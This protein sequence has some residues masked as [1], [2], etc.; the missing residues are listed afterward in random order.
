MHNNL[1]DYFI[2]SILFLSAL[3]GYRHGLI[4]SLGKMISALLAIV[5]A[6]FWR[7]DFINFLDLK[8]NIVNKLSKLIIQQVPVLALF[9]EEHFLSFIIKNEEILNPIQ[10][11]ACFIFQPISF[12]VLFL[13][14]YLFLM[15]FFKVL[16]YIASVGVLGSF[17][18]VLGMVIAILQT[19]LIFSIIAGLAIPPLEIAARLD[20]F[21]AAEFSN[22]MRDSLLIKYLGSLFDNLIIIINNMH[23]QLPW[24][25]I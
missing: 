11:L 17:N 16:S 25:A 15:L 9:E 12:V 10:Q 8:F 5:A 3:N 7:N 19:I 2:I 6:I 20:I 23:R 13:V 14:A 1:V 4:A 22:Y 24:P 18:R 21:G